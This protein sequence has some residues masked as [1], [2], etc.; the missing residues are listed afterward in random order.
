MLIFPVRKITAYDT[1]SL[2]RAKAETEDMKESDKR[3]LTLLEE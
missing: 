1:R 2:K 3:A